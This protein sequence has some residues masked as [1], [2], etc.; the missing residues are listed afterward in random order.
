MHGDIFP[1]GNA[2]G[3]HKDSEEFCY[4]IKTVTLSAI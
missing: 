1:N 4:I 2:F 3:V